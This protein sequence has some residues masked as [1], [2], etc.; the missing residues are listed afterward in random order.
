MQLV[1]K[2]VQC[3]KLDCRLALRTNTMQLQCDKDPCI[4]VCHANRIT[5][6]GHLYSTK[7]VANNYNIRGLPCTKGQ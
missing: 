5:P 6:Y 2:E 4:A 3:S 1:F 7:M